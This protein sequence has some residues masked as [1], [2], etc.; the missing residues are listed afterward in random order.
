MN[1]ER[2]LMKYQKMLRPNENSLSAGG[3]LEGGP[4]RLLPNTN[5]LFLRIV[6]SLRT[7]RTMRRPSN[8]LFPEMIIGIRMRQMIR[9]VANQIRA[10]LFMLS[11]I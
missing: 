11:E 8:D 6:L 5:H 3:I 9:S 10:L 7:N 4:E 1:L 2:T